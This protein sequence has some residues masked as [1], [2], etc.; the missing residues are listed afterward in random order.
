MKFILKYIKAIPAL[1]LIAALASCGQPKDLNFGLVHNVNVKSFTTGGITIEA[2][3]PIE[4]PN[5]YRIKA[6]NAD[7]SVLAGNKEIARIKQNLPV[8]L[9]GNSKGEYTINAT[10]SV[11]SGSIMSL[12]S[13]F[14]SNADLN[15]NGTARISSFLVHRDVQ[16]HQTGVQNYL[17]PIISGMKLF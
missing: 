17:K 14:N 1:V 13:V 10:I 11:G 4:N 9:P 5:G 12:M 7:V 15:L 6:Q 16:I 2:T 3:L 8:T